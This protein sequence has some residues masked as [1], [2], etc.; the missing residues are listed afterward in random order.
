MASDPIEATQAK[1]PACDYEPFSRNAY[2]TGKLMLARDFIDEQHYVVEKMRH[3]NQYLHG[4][5]VVCGLK[6]TQHDKASCRSHYVYVEPG[7]AVDCCG[8]DIV[9]TD[10]DILDILAQPAVIAIK[11]TKPHTLQICI[12]YRECPNEDIPVLYDDCG[13]DDTRCAPNRI[14]ESYEL[15]V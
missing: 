12:R 3:H 11:D 10:R 4:E 1:C 9:V 5:G 15:G 13:C 14:L 2:W 7:T 6:V 8:R